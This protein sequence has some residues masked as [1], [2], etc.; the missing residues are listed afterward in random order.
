M[1]RDLAKKLFREFLHGMLEQCDSTDSADGNGRQR[2]KPHRAPLPAHCADRGIQSDT[3][4]VEPNMEAATRWASAPGRTGGGGGGARVAPRSE[5]R[6]ETCA[7]GSRF[8]QAATQT[9]AVPVARRARLSSNGAMSACWM[10]SPR[11]V[12]EV[13]RSHDARGAKPEVLVRRLDARSLRLDAAEAV[14][15]DGHSPLVVVA[16]GTFPFSANRPFS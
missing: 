4:E 14:R 11:L 3:T 2:P 1:N 5:G 12:R 7:S 8:V 6:P 15:C 9:A 13:Q 16:I 10:N